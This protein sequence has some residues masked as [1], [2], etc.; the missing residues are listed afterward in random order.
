[1]TSHVVSIPSAPFRSASGAF[2]V[3]QVPAAQD[4]LVWL[5]VC[6]KTGAVAAVD[7]PDAENALAYCAAKGLTLSHVL[8][9]HTHGDHV[10]INQDLAQ[11]GLLAG[12]Q[13]IGPA[14]MRAQVPGL[15]Q[16]A[17]DGDVIEVGACRARVFRT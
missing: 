5:F 13:V 3:H 11:R 9:T 15:T 8:N 6:L 1:M 14:K 2:E 12:L 10:G 16:P 7:G 17:D 4:N